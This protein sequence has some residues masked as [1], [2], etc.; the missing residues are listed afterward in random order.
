M[1]LSQAL[2]KD[3]PI[4]VLCGHIHEAPSI[5][6]KPVCRVGSTLVANPGSRFGELSLITGSFDGRIELEYLNLP[7]RRS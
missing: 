1:D 3:P 5:S 7:L 6:R 2:L 4:A